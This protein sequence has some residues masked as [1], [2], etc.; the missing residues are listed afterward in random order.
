MHDYFNECMIEARKAYDKN[1]VPVGAVIVINNKI[2]S[3]AHNRRIELNDVTAHA[4]ILAIKE[5]EKVLG[6]WRLNGCDLYVTLKPCSMCSEIIKESRIDH[7]FYLLDKP[8][9]KKGY[10]KTE[11]SDEKKSYQQF[12]SEYSLLMSDFFKLKCKR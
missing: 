9:D 1:E 12:F 8:E 10:Y 6:D 5:A 11:F 2:I 4:E 3:R 7:V